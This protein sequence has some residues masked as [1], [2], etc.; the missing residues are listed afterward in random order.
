MAG[1]MLRAWAV[2]SPTGVLIKAS[3]NVS[4]TA[5]VT[6]GKYTVTLSDGPISTSAVVRGTVQTGPASLPRFVTMDTVP[7]GNVATFITPAAAGSLNDVASH[8]ELWE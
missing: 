6:V 5:K 4:G 7:A 1:M 3:P 2:V 8:V